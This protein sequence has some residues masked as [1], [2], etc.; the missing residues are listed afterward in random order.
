MTIRTRVASRTRDA[1]TTRRRSR[2]RA[3]DPRRALHTWA[4]FLAPLRER[5]T[6]FAGAFTALAVGAALLTASAL[7][8]LSG[9]SG[10]P[11]RFT[12]TPVLVHSGPH[13]PLT[14][15]EAAPF[16][17]R[18]TERLVRELGALP[19]V[20]AA[21][22]DRPFPAQALRAGQPV[23]EQRP[24]DLAGNSWSA[25]ALAPYRLTSGHAPAAANEVAVDRSLGLA[26]GRSVTLLTAE[27]PT[28]FTVSGTV[29]GPGF[30]VTDS[31]AAALSGGVRVI[32]LL[33]DGGA[34]PAEVASAAR[35][36][37]GGDG[38]VLSGTGR[39]AL[40]PGADEKTR[41]IGGQVVS[42]MTGLAAF[43]TVYVVSSAFAFTVARRRR[44]FGLL[45]TIGATP[46]RI[47]RMVYGEGLAI[48]ATAAATGVLIGTVYAPDLG[49]LLVDHGFQPRGFTVERRPWLSALAFAAGVGIALAGVWS[50]ARRAA[51]TSPM[52]ALREAAVDDRPL[53]P[54][55]LVAGL[56]CT[57]LGIGAAVAGASAEPARMI[58]LALGAG[59]GL[60][61]G[62]ALLMPGLVPPLV[63]AA[64]LPF[65][66]SRGAVAT[67]TRETALT[68]V[69]RT[70]AT[71][72]PVFATVAFTVLI[73]ANTEMTAESAKDHEVA[74]VTAHATVVP[75]RTA[76]LGDAQVRRI[77]G[78]SLLPTVVRGGPGRGPIAA[79]G[80]EP[81]PYAAVHGAPRP[82]SGALADLER[83]GTFGT[84][85][86]GLAALGARAGEA[87][88][89]TFADGTVRRLR[90]AVVLEDRDLPYGT[91]L[92]AR[93]LVRAHDP[94]ALTSAVHRTGAAVAVA[95]GKEITVTAF[96]GR[97]DA[98]ENRLID[99]FT[100]LLVALSAGYT[101]IAVA[102]TLL[103]ATAD[104]A[105]DLRILR[106]SGATPRQVVG[107]VAA[108][109]ALV[110]AIGSALG[111]LAALPS[112]LGIRAGLSG[113]LGVPVELTV[114]WPTILAAVAATGALALASS[115]IPA[116]RLTRA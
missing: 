8:L 52:A 12:G 85:R 45:R 17:P 105:P 75:D 22:P 74:A 88:L 43:V 111:G 77:T 30:H 106:R 69:R 59:V 54:A 47:R 1:L 27:G 113:T 53:G 110:V 109:T 37:A 23:G 6:A 90:I 87:V 10:I 44:E 25:A 5:R 46:R 73:T 35:R 86:S 104:R 32:G 66:R 36:I 96:G 7:I 63:K 9:G 72:G 33:L 15:D 81:G 41:W 24:G 82:V 99:V 94:A 115:T 21:V 101:G 64:T 76:G 98:A 116:W 92:L 114:P 100:V 91:A 16:A 13:D 11:D 56:G 49:A 83:P 29:D 95:G 42:A 2:V 3:R 71:I 67:L 112:V 89:L 107:A 14:F 20:R 39:E 79:V 50:A 38:R 68:S 51:R 58:T 57:A 31:R 40:A 65:A 55:R 103:T 26:P 28:P 78:A 93:D 108:E 97:A 80:I 19:G 70:A 102:S 60:I 61:T 48:G 18:T 84:S 62:G 4:A 34:D